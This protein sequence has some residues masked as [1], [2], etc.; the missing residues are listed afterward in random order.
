MYRRFKMHLQNN[1]RLAIKY[2][3]KKNDNFSYLIFNIENV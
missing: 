2:E 3:L 1:K